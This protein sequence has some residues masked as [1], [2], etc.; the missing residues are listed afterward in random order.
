MEAPLDWAYALFPLQE[1]GGEILSLEWLVRLAHERIDR[2]QETGDEAHFGPV[3]HWSHILKIE[4]GTTGDWPAQVNARTGAA[5]GPAR[6]RSPAELMVRLD[7]LLDAT[8]FET[9]IA[10]AADEKGAG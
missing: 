4:Q 7:E 5:V 1:E 10:R 6:T 3:L 8:E 9:A 2:A